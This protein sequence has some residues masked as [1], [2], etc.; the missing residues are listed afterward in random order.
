MKTVLWGFRTSRVLTACTFSLLIPNHHVVRMS[1]Q[2][3]WRKRLPRGH[4]GW[5]I[6]WRN[7]SWQRTSAL[8]LTVNTKASKYVKVPI[9]GF[10]NPDQLRD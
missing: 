5:N 2:Y 4:G 6:T 9:L 10:S 7:R 1:R 8:Q 3:C